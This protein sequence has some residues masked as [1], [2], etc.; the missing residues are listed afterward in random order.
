MTDRP[1]TMRERLAIALIQAPADKEKKKAYWLG[2]ADAVLEFG[3]RA[4]AGTAP[5]A[6][7]TASRR[8]ALSRGGYSERYVRRM[9]SL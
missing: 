2:L 4:C 6:A 3:A 7:S 5:R 8:L 1:P 9:L